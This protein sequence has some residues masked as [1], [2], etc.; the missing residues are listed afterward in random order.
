M[1]RLRENAVAEMELNRA[2]LRLYGMSEDAI[3]HHAENIK[4]GGEWIETRLLASGPRT[5]PWFQECGPRLVQNN[6]IV[7]LIWICILRICGYQPHVVGWR[8]GPLASIW[9][10]DA[11]RP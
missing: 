5:N 7:A 3:G 11:T 6:E 10:S 9:Y 1:P 4:R 2:S 8:S